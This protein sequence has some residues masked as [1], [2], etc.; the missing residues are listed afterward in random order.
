M[1]RSEDGEGLGPARP[2]KSRPGSTP[3]LRLAGRG[4]P[5]LSPAHRVPCTHGLSCP[6]LCRVVSTSHSAKQPSVS[7]PFACGNPAQTWGSGMRETGMSRPGWPLGWWEEEGASP[8]ITCAADFWDVCT[9]EPLMALSGHL[10]PSPWAAPGGALTHLRSELDRRGK[11]TWT[12]LPHSPDRSCRSMLPLPRCSLVSTVPMTAC[13]RHGLGP[14]PA[15]VRR[16][17]AAL[18]GT[19]AARGPCRPVR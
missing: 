9:V 7:R 12:L 10:F 11:C 8:R 1:T 17:A 16:T 13:C 14:D 19:G 2:R 5:R 6:S 15:L 18:S 4:K 3:S